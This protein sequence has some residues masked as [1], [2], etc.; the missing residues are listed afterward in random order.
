LPNALLALRVTDELIQPLLAYGVAGLGGPPERLDDLIFG[1]QPWPFR[2]GTTSAPA[3]PAQNVPQASIISRRF[4]KKVVRRYAASTALG[5]AWASAASAI[6][7]GIEVCSAAQ[8]R[9]LDRIPWTVNGSFMSRKIL[10]SV[11]L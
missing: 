10:V 1:H 3:S 8:S 6:S 11:M 5:T 9:K 4:S 2:I 7:P